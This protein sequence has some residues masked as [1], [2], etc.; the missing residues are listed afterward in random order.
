MLGDILRAARNPIQ[1]AILLLVITGI[2]FE[3]KIPSSWSEW[4]DTVIGKFVIVIIFIGLEY[5]YHWTLGI[6]W[7]LFALLM[8]SPQAVRVEGFSDVSVVDK[9]KGIWFVEKLLKENP[10][11][12]KERE[13]NTYPVQE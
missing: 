5:S 3:S 12:I 6:L 9:S 10:V 11:A 7:L 13:V 8:I 2:V 1:I 4:S